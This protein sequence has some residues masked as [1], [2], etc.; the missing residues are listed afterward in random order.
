MAATDIVAEDC[1][2]CSIVE[3][4]DQ[5]VEVVCQDKSWFA[6]FPQSRDSWTYACHSAEACGQHDRRVRR[7]G[8]TR[9]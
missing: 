1:D 4:R 7:A 2:F 6:F 8:T 3:G 5:S 9:W